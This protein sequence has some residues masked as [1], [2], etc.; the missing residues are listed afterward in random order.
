MRSKAGRRSFTQEEHAFNRAL[1]RRMETARKLAKI[2]VRELAVGLGVSEAQVY[3]YESG[4]D[5]IPIYRLVLAAKLFAL[6]VSLLLGES[7]S[8]EE[9]LIKVVFSC[10]TSEI[11]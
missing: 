4:R 10:A 5:R 2:G 6:P 3:W 11:V 7:D 9:S 1:G 8:V